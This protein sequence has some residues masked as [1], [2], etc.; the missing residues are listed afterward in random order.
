MTGTLVLCYLKQT[1]IQSML[2]FVSGSK[3]S[4]RFLFPNICSFY[5]EAPLL[6][7]VC[8]TRTIHEYGL[9]R[10]RKQQ[11]LELHNNV[12]PAITGDHL[13]EPYLLLF[14]LDNEN[15]H[16]TSSD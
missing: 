7:N 3:K 13:L 1:T 11:E 4:R 5:C 8:S 10:T 9:F 6:M 2:L 14:R 15:Y 16:T 12:L